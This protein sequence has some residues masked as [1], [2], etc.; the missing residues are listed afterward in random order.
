[1]SENGTRVNAARDLVVPG[2]V[3]ARAGFDAGDDV[4]FEVEEGGLRVVPDR[5]RKVYVE[6]T[7]RC[8]LDCAM[9]VRRAWH[10]APGDMPLERYARLL[11]GLPGGEPD[12][13]TLAFGGF[14]EPLVHPSWLDLVRE[15][16][17][18]R[19][20]VE[21][22]SNGLALDGEAAGALVELGVAQVTVSI[23]GGDE[24]SYRRMRGTA[25]EA[26]TLAVERLLRARLHSRSRL[27]VGVAAVAMRS[28]VES[29][30]ALV[31]WATDRQLDF[32]SISNVVPHTE[33][34]AAE[35]L[36]DRAGWASVFF[37]AAWRPSLR[38]ARLDAEAVTRPLADAVWPRGLTFPPPSADDGAWRNRCRFVHEGVCAVSWDGRVA[39]C[40]SLLHAH[41]EHVNN[42]ARRV[43]AHLVGHIDEVPLAEIWK[44]AG[45]R[46]YRR[47]VRAFDF[48]PCFHCGGCPL[49]ETN[50]EDC[51]SNPAPV[52]GEC[53]WAQGLVLCP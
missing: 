42:Q 31:A 39:P 23:D 7:T 29:L 12:R 9:C 3:L 20:R 10:H 1:M 15:A 25:R 41:T 26:A 38:V 40:L 50:L 46:E 44:D 18:R 47:R 24:A 28:T 37:P 33:A 22:I 34:L 5:L 30:P 52:C 53:L 45:Y 35:T 32:V 8:N 13:L 6:T 19:H 36:W 4:V 21:L 48:P 49:T 2:D 51:Y 27:Q 14:G 16:R 11:D 43:E 17:A